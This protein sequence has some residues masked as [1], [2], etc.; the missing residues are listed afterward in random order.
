MTSTDEKR[1]LK[2]N[3]VI[4]YEGD[5][6]VFWDD[7]TST[8]ALAQ[9]TGWANHTID[10]YRFRCASGDSGGCRYNYLDR[11][12]IQDIDFTFLFNFDEVRDAVFS[13]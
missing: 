4:L 2:N 1:V 12:T 11:H 10:T 5:V 13:E 9:I 6:F 7:E 8:P 3:D